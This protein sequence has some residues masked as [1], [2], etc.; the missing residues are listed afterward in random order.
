MTGLTYADA[1]VDIIEVAKLHNQIDKILSNTY[2]TRKH[3]IGEPLD[4]HQHYAGLIGISQDKALAVHTD[5]V[6]T[7]VLIAEACHKYDTIGIDC[8]AMNVNDVICVGA[9]PIALVNYLALEDPQPTLIHQIMLGLARGARMAGVA[10]VSG[11]TAIMRDVVRGFDLAATVIGIVDRNKIITGEK[12]EEGDVI[13]GL[14]SSGIHSNGLTL[15]RKV[16]FNSRTRADIANETLR[17]TKIYVQEAMKMMRSTS[18][19]HGFAHITGGAYSKLRRIGL[20]AKVGFTLDAMPRPNRIFQIIQKE[21]KISDREMYRTFN[22]GIGF[23]VICTERVS[24]RL[25]KIVPEARKIGQV[26]GTRDVAVR[27]S[28][29]DVQIE[30]W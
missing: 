17:P 3:K 12:S 4:V 14:R 25:R 27:I 6:G 7:K 18:E 13:L 30:K 16:L 10:I 2:R 29:R 5:G 26:T 19:I 15:A 22:M 11:E 20:R 24:R 21:G 28:G 23:L 8:V 1:G 9:E